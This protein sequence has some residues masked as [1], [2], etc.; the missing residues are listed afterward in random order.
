M[1]LVPEGRCRHLTCL[2]RGSAPHAPKRLVAAT[3][4][5][6]TRGKENLPR[7]TRQAPIDTRPGSRPRLLCKLEPSKTIPGEKVPFVHVAVIARE[8]LQ[9]HQCSSS[10]AYDLR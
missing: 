2:R 4:A 3:G 10:L 6:D 8:S 7:S 5:G 1:Q 9:R